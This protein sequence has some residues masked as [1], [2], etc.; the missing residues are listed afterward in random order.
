[1]KRKLIVGVFV[2]VCLTLFFQ[3]AWTAP[4]TVNAKPPVSVSAPAPEELVQN[5]TR[6][7]NSLPQFYVSGTAYYDKVYQDNDKIQYSMDFDYYVKRPGEFQMDLEGLNQNKQILFNGK[8][9][10][11]YDEDKAVYGVIDTPPT[12]DAALDKAAK[13]Y[14][15]SLGL[16]DV[17][18]SDFAAT[19]LDDVVKSA[20]IGMMDVGDI[21][22]HSVAFAKKDRNI[23]LWIED[24]DKPF[25]RKVVITFKNNPAMPAWIVEI[26]DWNLSPELPDG[27]STFVVKP[28]MKKI[29]FLKTA[30]KQAPAAKSREEK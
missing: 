28:G 4:E 8:N 17:A 16:L 12:I 9:L 15:L 3:P 26:S 6:F 23:Q 27:W 29:E 14:G 30:D 2:L 13:E 10:T 20:Y 19:V 18:R 7:M 1:M 5:M 11:M 21:P 25:L 22:C 24:G